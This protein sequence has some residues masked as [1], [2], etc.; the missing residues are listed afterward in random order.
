MADQ[1][2]RRAISLAQMIGRSD[3]IVN[4]RRKMRIGEFASA[5]ADASETKSQNADSVQ[6]QPLRDTPGGG[7]FL[8]TGKA[9]SEQRKGHRLAERQIEYRRQSLAL[10]TGKIKPFTAHD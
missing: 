6:R 8:A 10:R 1:D 2:R 5:A 3:Q 9:M 4:V 7:Y